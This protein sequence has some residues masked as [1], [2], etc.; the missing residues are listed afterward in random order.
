MPTSPR[1]LEEELKRCPICGQT[2]EDVEFGVC[3]ARKDGRNLYC[4]ACI[5]LKVTASRRA[6][7]EYQIARNRLLKANSEPAA[8]VANE[9]QPQAP[10]TLGWRSRKP[11]VHERVRDAIVRGA[12]TYNGIMA[13]VWDHRTSKDEVGDAIAKL[14][15]D[16]REI[17]TEMVGETRHYFLREKPQPKP[18]P[19]KRPAVRAA[20]FTWT[21]LCQPISR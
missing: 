12:R 1:K 20:P 18:Q 3:R 16:T 6:L 13:V 15:L 4:K 17:R 2:E 19:E 5:R 9:P 14:L 10:P 11:P 21:A 8:E 7:R